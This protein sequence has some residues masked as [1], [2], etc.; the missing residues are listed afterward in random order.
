[1]SHFQFFEKGEIMVR[2]I[3][4][5]MLPGTFRDKVSTNIDFSDS[6]IVQ[7]D[8]PVVASVGDGNLPTMRMLNFV[9]N[10]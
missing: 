5:L 7:Y 1:M 4:Q 3:W 6:T 8:V 2:T 9:E 10:V